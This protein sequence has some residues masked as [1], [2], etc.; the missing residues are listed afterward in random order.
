[1]LL[2]FEFAKVNRVLRR[3]GLLGLWLCCLPLA[4]SAQSIDI[5][6]PSPV[7]SNDVTGRID[8][9][10]IGDARLTDHFYAFTAVPGDLL[11]TVEGRNLN[12][13]VDVFTSSVCV[14]FLSFRFMLRRRPR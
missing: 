11:I 13:D 4:I 12:G 10:D 5:A 3:I 1:M 9:R 14:R 2:Y 8:P 6:A 7:T